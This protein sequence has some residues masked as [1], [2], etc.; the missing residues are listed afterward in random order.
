MHDINLKNIYG[1]FK[2]EDL[3]LCALEV[4]PLRSKKRQLATIAKNQAPEAARL[5]KAPP[6]IFMS[7]VP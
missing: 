7:F 2:N 6:V 1:L 4:F 5:L 3:P